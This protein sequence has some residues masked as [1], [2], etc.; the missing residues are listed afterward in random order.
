MNIKNRGLRV[1]RA[2]DSLNKIIKNDST[3]NGRISPISI[4][5]T[6]KKEPIYF[7]ALVKDIT[8]NEEFVCSFPY[9]SSLHQ[10]SMEITS[11]T[12]SKECSVDFDNQLCETVFDLFKECY[13]IRE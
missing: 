8:T 3:F 11:D 4:I 6:S 13:F 10:T 12:Y 2:L 5:Y 7:I 1:K 9:I